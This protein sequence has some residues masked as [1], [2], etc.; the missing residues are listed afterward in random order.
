M[1]KLYAERANRDPTGTQPSRWASVPPGATTAAGWSVAAAQRRSGV[2]A[3]SSRQ[4]QHEHCRV[5]ALGHSDPPRPSD[6]AAWPSAGRSASKSASQRPSEGIPNRRVYS[7]VPPKIRRGARQRRFSARPL[8]VR[9]TGV[10]L[11]CNRA[12]PR[13]VVGSLFRA[14]YRARPQGHRSISRQQRQ[15]E[16][17]RA[18]DLGTRTP[19]RPYHRL[20]RFPSAPHLAAI[21]SWR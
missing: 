8:P 3:V 9:R 5:G 4:Q 21:R 15:Q 11:D 16:H 10:R 13:A 1:R 18:G 7:R 20:C 19:P 2:P 12:C 6:A 17:L 14:D